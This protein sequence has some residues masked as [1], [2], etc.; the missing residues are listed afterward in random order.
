VN[1]EY[2]QHARQI[3]Y[4]S[5]TYISTTSSATGLLTDYSEEPCRT[6]RN[7]A[8]REGS[9]NNPCGLRATSRRTRRSVE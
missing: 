2:A 9:C 6:C 5:L 4:L 3:Q 8:N 7:E 1:T